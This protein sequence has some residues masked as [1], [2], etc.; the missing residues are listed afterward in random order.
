MDAHTIKKELWQFIPTT[1][2][3][4]LPE[5]TSILSG[6][7]WLLRRSNPVCIGKF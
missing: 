7:G 2:G 4:T 6:Q 5:L 1:A 3:S